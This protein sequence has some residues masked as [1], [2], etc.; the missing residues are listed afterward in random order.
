MEKKVRRYDID[1]LRVLVFAL[2]IFYHVGM[3]FIPWG[4]HIKN[5]EIGNEMRWPMLFLNQWR[6]PIL[7]VISGMGTYYALGH[8]TLKQFSWERIKRLY[9]PLAVGMV[10]IVP[11]QVYFER[12]ADGD[13][14]GSFFEFLFGG[15]AFS[16]IYPEGNFSWHHLWFLPYLLLFSLLLGPVFLRL[17]KPTNRFIDWIA[18][19][20]A[21]PLGIYL[22][23]LPLYLIEAFVE[24]YFPVTH[25]LIDDWFTVSFYFVLFFYGFVLI[26]TRD[27]F[28]K[29]IDK[30]KRS[31]LVIAIIAFTLQVIIWQQQDSYFIHFTEAMVKVVNLWSWILV[32][33]AYGAKYLN[34]KSELL[35]YCNRA[36]YPFYILHQT[37]TVAIGFYIK[38]LPWNIWAK[39]LILVVGTFFGSWILYEFVIRRIRFLHPLF[40]LKRS[41]SSGASSTSSP[42]SSSVIGI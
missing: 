16:G 20:I 24:P 38:D 35:A 22:F 30:N 39:F 26:A 4:W 40:G 10:L 14:S 3:F 17:K 29:V 21:K 33:F 36:V 7:F 8:R 41:Y 1:W 18:K 19:V 34:K 28:W 5:N 23:V 12:V 13:F 25:A 15:T 31:Y 42:S 2:L 11:P 6:L 32:I 37:I 27:A 9:I